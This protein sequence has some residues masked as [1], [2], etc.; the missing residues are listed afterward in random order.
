MDQGP[1]E[2]TAPATSMLAISFAGAWGMTSGWAGGPGGHPQSRSGL[3]PHFL[4]DSHMSPLMWGHDDSPQP[5]LDSNRN[6]DAVSTVTSPLRVFLWMN[7]DGSG[8]LMRGLARASQGPYSWGWA[9][10]WKDSP[11]LIQMKSPVMVYRCWRTAIGLR[12]FLENIPSSVP[13]AP[14]CRSSRGAG[15][16]VEGDRGHLVPSGPKDFPPTYWLSLYQVKF[17]FT[18]ICIRTV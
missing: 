11:W 12:L 18:E 15:G 4:P 7:V 3:G 5:S 14:A 17:A 1:Q 9:G 16:T 6:S 8:A 10:R 13:A 2:G